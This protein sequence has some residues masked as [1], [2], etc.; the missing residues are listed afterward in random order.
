MSVSLSEMLQQPIEINRRRETEG[1]A[2]LRVTAMIAVGAVMLFVAA[3]ALVTTGP[4]TEFSD[5][6]PELSAGELD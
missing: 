5:V 2:L 3:R 6:T 4:M 1:S